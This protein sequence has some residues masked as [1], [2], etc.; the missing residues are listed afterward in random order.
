[1]KIEKKIDKKIDKKIKKKIGKKIGKKIEK[2]IEKKTMKALKIWK[3]QENLTLKVIHANTIHSGII[4]ALI[5]L[6]A[7]E[8]KEVLFK[9]LR[10]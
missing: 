6:S 8:E 3:K 4:F 10:D 5:F 7:M 1:M 9:K 2:K